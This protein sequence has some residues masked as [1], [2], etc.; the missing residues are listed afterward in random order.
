[1]RGFNLFK[2]G[3]EGPVYATEAS[4]DLMALLQLDILDVARR[5]GSPMPITQKEVQK[6]VLHTIPLKYG[7]T[8]DVAPD[9]KITLYNAGHILGSAMFFTAEASDLRKPGFLTYIT[10]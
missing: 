8:T 4:R 5:E 3:Y 7:E 6:M 9:V 2:Y 1:M 10:R